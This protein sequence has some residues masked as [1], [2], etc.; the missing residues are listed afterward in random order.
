M[1][2]L[3]QIVVRTQFKGVVAQFVPP[4]IRLAAK[5]MGNM[6]S[7]SAAVEVIAGPVLG[8]LS[9]TIGRKR[10]L[11]LA[12]IIQAVTHTGVRLFPRRLWINFVDRV[13]AGAGLFMHIMLSNAV[14]ADLFEELSLPRSALS[15]SLC[16]PPA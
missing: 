12:P 7:A 1:S 15:N 13:L 11:L 2:L 9:D 10:M 16:F 14:L 4:S 3:S 6:S 8:R 5:T